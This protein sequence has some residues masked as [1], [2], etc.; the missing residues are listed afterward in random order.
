MTIKEQDI[1]DALELINSVATVEGF[2]SDVHLQKF[3]KATETIRNYIAP[4][5][6]Y[7]FDEGTGEVKPLSSPPADVREALESLKTFLY[8]KLI[9]DDDEWEYPDVLIQTISNYIS[10]A[11]IVKPLKWYGDIGRCD[12][13]RAYS[14]E[15]SKVAKLWGYKTSYQVGLTLSYKGGNMFTDKEDARKGAEI[16]HK[17]FI[18]E[19]LEYSPHTS[20]PDVTELVECLKVGLNNLTVV[21]KGSNGKKG[22][23]TVGQIPEWKLRQTLANYGGE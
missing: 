9:L 12:N 10:P 17:N 6:P 16:A 8:D 20:Q 18:L 19:A 5:P 13:G 4:K 11:G 23:V 22:A 21:D 3:K 15:F 1:R 14:L 7:V 2:V